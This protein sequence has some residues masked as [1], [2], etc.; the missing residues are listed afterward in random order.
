MCAKL[1]LHCLSAYQHCF[2]EGPFLPVGFDS[3]LRVGKVA[4]AEMDV[5]ICGGK[6]GVPHEAHEGERVNAGFNSSR[7]VGVAAIVERE[8]WPNQKKT[9]LM[10]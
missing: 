3:L 2:C 10:G 6:V 7:A 5:A 1:P 4:L 8:S 9:A